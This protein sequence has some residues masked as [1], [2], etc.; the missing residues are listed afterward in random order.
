MG[1][2]WSVYC[3]YAKKTWLYSHWKPGAAMMKTLQSLVAME[4]AIMTTSGAT[5]D[6]KVAI[7]TT[8]G[9][10]LYL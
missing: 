9:F 6:Y 5:N 8:G 3:A 10:Q 4:A 2:L 1:E 7:T